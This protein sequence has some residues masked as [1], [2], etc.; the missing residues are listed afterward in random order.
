[1]KMLY[2]VLRAA[3]LACLPALTVPG[4]ILAETVTVGGTGSSTPLIRQL[5]E[6]YLKIEPEIKVEVIDPPMGS[7][8][9]IRAMMAGAIDLA[10]PGKPLTDAQ[11]EQGGWHQELGRTPFLFVTSKQPPLS[12]TLEQIAA[13]YSGGTTRWADGS[14]IRLVMRS[15]Q[16]SDSRILSSL[17]PVMESAVEIALE[18]PGLLIAPNDL[19]N[20]ELLNKT[21]GSLG[22]TN[23]G[24]LQSQE[25]N[26]QIIT[27]D[28][29]VATLDALYRGVYS[30]Y[31]ELYIAHGPK[32]SPAARGFLEFILSASG[33][34]VMN[35]EG[36]LLSSPRP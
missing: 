20:L 14:P 18:R 10:V 33:Q 36:Y 13:I 26:L 6:A 24:L 15:R 32:V 8:G 23:L 9:S 19:I 12:L 29:I 27:V 25:Y 4:P 1:M 2:R 35:R 7:S 22:T 21:P 5:G 28:G 30:H 31:K 16:E 3:W 11:R 17:A 34:E